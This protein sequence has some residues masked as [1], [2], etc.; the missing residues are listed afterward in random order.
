M[1]NYNI[2][3]MNDSNPFLSVC[4]TSYK[5]VKE[6]Q[7][8]LK[9]VDSQSSELIEIVVSE[10]CSSERERIKETVETYAKSSPYKV[11]FNTNEHNLGYDR[12]LKRLATLASGEY[13]FY[14]SDDDCLYPNTLDSLIEALKEKKPA[15]AYAPF[16]YG[17]DEA[18]EAKRKHQGSEILEKGEGT[19]SK[20][21]YDAILFSG[22][23]F[24]REY[25]L[26]IDGER[27]KN[28][29]YIQVYMFLDVMYRYG[30]YYHDVLMIDSVS[31][32]ENAYG[33]VDSSNGGNDL[34]ANR[35]SIFSNIEFNKGL[36]RVIKMFDEDNGTHI[37]S[38]FSK[39]YSLRSLAGL[40]RARRYGLKTY[41]D[42]WD[43]VKN[44]G[45]ELSPIAYT[46]YIIV[47]FFGASFSKSLFILPRKIL[48]KVR[49][50]N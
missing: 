41:N 42:Y 28:L 46:Y 6:L 1:I 47:Y 4:V 21:V 22:L 25:L 3:M 33:T 31:D 11:V 43:R 36:F 18:K 2:F 38:E 45:I 39:E 34:L 26:G 32:G 7:R 9:S 5:R 16:W 12:N 49:G 23:T 35:E 19:V 20:R 50:H 15:M 13:V 27:F 17:Y 44:S 24:K 40:C 48:K 30:G 29:N 14:M 37:F 8:C 10:D